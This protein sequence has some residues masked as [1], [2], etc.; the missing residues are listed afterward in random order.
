MHPCTNHIESQTT[1][2]TFL[3]GLPHS[4]RWMCLARKN[5]CGKN[6]IRLFDMHGLPS[7]GQFELQS[8]HFPLTTMPLRLTLKAHQGFLLLEP[9]ICNKYNI[10]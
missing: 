10:D 4:C 7:I 6:S 2:C 3:L 1:F 9:K 8:A 5:V